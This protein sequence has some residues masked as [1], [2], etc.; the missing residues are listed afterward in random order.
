MACRGTA[1]L[2]LYYELLTTQF[3]KQRTNNKYPSIYVEVLTS[4]DKW[5]PTNGTPVKTHLP[6]EHKHSPFGDKG[7]ESNRCLY[8]PTT[9]MVIARRTP[10]YLDR[11]SPQ[12][13][14]VH[15][16]PGPL[17]R[18]TIRDTTQLTSQLTC[19]YALNCKSSQTI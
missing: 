13:H 11:T 14:Y 8:Q 9:R 6:A 18:L 17:W 3:T 15:H 5:M 12:Y 16:N 4:H 1:L 7:G 19:H 2:L 10:K